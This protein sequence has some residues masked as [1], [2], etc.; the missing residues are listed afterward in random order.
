M[1]VTITTLGEGWHNYHHAFPWDYRT[2]ELGNF[3]MNFTTIFID[4][5]E[6]IGQAYDLKSAKYDMIVKRM[7]RTGDYMKENNN[8]ERLC[9]KTLKD[10]EEKVRDLF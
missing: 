7:E 4:W 9:D 2:A 5:M 6:K 3:N 8:G 10:E 1:G